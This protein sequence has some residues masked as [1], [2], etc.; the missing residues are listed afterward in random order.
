MGRDG[1][2]AGI[3]TPNEWLAQAI[4]Q[5]GVSLN[6]LAGMVGIEPTWLQRWV[7]NREAIPR[8]H[9][10]EIASQVARAGEVLRVLR[11]KDCE[12]LQF[13]LRK[14]SEELA[15]H[16]ARTTSDQLMTA[17]MNRIGFLLSITTPSAEL[18]A[19]YTVDAM[20]VVRT[21]TRA[22]EEDYRE[23]LFSP[24][25]V[26]RHFQFPLNGLVDT[27]LDIA[28]LSQPLIASMH[29]V[30]LDRQASGSRRVVREHTIYT[31]ARYSAGFDRQEIARLLMRESESADAWMRRTAL[32]ML[33]KTTRDLDAVS[34]H[35]HQHRRDGSM[36]T[37]AIGQEAA[38]A[39]D[40]I[41]DPRAGPL[42][43]AVSFDRTVHHILRRLEQPESHGDHHAVDLQTLLFILD[44]TGPSPF[45]RPDVT[46]ALV[47]VVEWL[48]EVD[49]PDREVRLVV[50]QSLASFNELIA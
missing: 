4:Q 17:L 34:R 19:Q 32:Y 12:E 3:P 6:R 9:L 27:L 49:P 28:D 20:Y 10:A 30:A 41:L 11:L 43:E 47:R 8:H 38:Y 22:A 21:W 18:F 46:R 33:V 26:A 23:A 31:L 44:T 2:P 36:A 37:A 35:L 13:R 16:C 40:A 1:F 39:R 50:K 48:R 5:R 15:R 24:T 25:N 45:R 14:R 7:S 29:R 42:V